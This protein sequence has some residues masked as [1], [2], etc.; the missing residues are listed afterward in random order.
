MNLKQFATKGGVVISPCGPGWGGRWQYT[1]DAD[2]G[3]ATC[4]FKTKTEAYD[5]WLE[6]RF[7]PKLA[8][9]IRELLD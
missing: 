4:G 2:F 3:I 6:C 1:C 8:E 7:G 9:A 5:H